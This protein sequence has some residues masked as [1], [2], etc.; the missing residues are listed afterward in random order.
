MAT[1]RIYYL[2]ITNKSEMLVTGSDPNFRIPHIDHPVAIADVKK[3]KERRKVK[4]LF[5]DYVEDV[6]ESKV[7]I[8]KNIDVCFS[9]D[10]RN[11]VVLVHAINDTDTGNYAINGHSFVKTYDIPNKTTGLKVPIKLD[12][13]SLKLFT[14]GDYQTKDSPLDKCIKSVLKKLKKSEDEGKGIKLGDDK[15]EDTVKIYRFYRP[16]L[17]VPPFMVDPVASL[18]AMQRYGIRSPYNSPYASPYN[19]PLSS[20]YSSPYS[21]PL[22]SRS[23]PEMPSR[24]YS[25]GDAPRV[26]RSPRMGRLEGGY[27]EKYMKYKLK[28]LALKQDSLI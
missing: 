28:Y 14:A 24:R 6:I 9:D 18:F 19:S 25:P 26:A 11:T 4:K 20:P 8:G 15:T 1:T 5:R 22:S 10:T 17:F 3:D 12:T 7:E 27:Y 16:G 13:E 2:I 21:S 23:R